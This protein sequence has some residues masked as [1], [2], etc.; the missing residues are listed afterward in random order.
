M[1]HVGTEFGQR[2]CDPLGFVRSPCPMPTLA[3]ALE[4]AH[5]GN[6]FSV[7]AGHGARASHSKRTQMLAARVAVELGLNLDEIRVVWYAAVLHDIGKLG[8]HEPILDKPGE[9]NGNE[10]KMVRRHPETGATMLS[11]IAGFERVRAA[12]AA[13]H[14]RFDGRGYPAGLVGRDIPIEARLISV[15]DAHDAMTSDRPYRKALSHVRAVEQ[16]DEGAG[17]QFDPA[18]VEATIGV[19]GD[20]GWSRAAMEQ[21]SGS[22][23]SFPSAQ[24]RK[25]KE[26]KPRES[27]TSA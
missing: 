14:E 18:V 24:G 3:F 12:V 17:S 21:E 8:I 23:L 4:G 2:G 13:H 26:E 9:L 6:I 16:L 5:N 1:A 11:G 10:W 19:L 22:P 25:R 15:A 27:R 7:E 20:D